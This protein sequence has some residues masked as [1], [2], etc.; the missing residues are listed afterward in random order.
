MADFGIVCEF[1]PMHNGHVRLID[2]AKK[3]GAER[4]VCVMSGNAVQRGELAFADKYTRAKI[5][6]DCGADLVLELPYPYCAA[7]AE[8]FAGAGIRILSEL[9]D[10]VIFGSER[11]DIELLTS[12]ARVAASAAS[13]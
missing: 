1:N 2:E 13:A 3:R 6:V 10:N 7:S 12:A 4:V 5:A 9:C 11:G 8:F